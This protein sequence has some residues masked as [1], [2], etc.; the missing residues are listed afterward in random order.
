MKRRWQILL[1]II[2]YVLLLT[3]ALGFDVIRLI[4]GK[5]LALVI[6]GS[7]ILTVPFYEKG[8]TWMELTYVFGRKAIEAGFIQTFLLL[9]SMFQGMNGNER[10]SAAEIAMH[11][12]P[13]L[14]GFCFQIFF[15][16]KQDCQQ[17]RAEHSDMEEKHEKGFI[18]VKQVDFAKFGLTKREL[19]IADLIIKGKTNKEIAEALFISETTVKKHVSNI[20]EKTG[21]DKREN[22]TKI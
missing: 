10:I 11:F 8:I 21:V 19:E 12:R 18:E 22:L 13:V 9:F 17:E 20:F 14:Y 16:E 4:D 7:L 1:S 6:L 5:L 3:G 2:L 15:A